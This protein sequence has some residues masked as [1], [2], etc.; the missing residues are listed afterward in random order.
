MTIKTFNNQYIDKIISLAQKEMVRTLWLWKAK[1]GIKIVQRAINDS[2]D[3]VPVIVDG[4]FGKKSVSAIN[5][6]NSSTMIVSLSSAISGL[7]ETKDPDYITI[8][9]AELG[10]KRSKG[11][12][13][14]NAQ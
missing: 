12:S 13:T 6:I 14:I 10:V 5:S 2:G 11:K 8:A 4:W 9:K 7:T 1:E 3:S